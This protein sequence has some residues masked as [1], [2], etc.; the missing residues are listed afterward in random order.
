MEEIDI[1]R[2]TDIVISEIRNTLDED[3]LNPTELKKSSD[4]VISKAP[5]PISEPVI[6][7]LEIYKEYAESNL[8]NIKDSLESYYPDHWDL[9]INYNEIE[10]IVKNCKNKDEI[11]TKVSLYDV[12]YVDVY[13]IIIHFPEIVIKNSRKEEHLIRDLYIK[14]NLNMNFQSTNSGSYF[15]GCRTTITYAEYQSRYSHSHLPRIRLGEGF[16]GFCLGDTTLATLCARLTHSFD[17]ESFDLLLQSLKSYV[18]WESL[19]G[20]PY[21]K[22]SELS[23]N[24]Q[25]PGNLTATKRLQ[26][27][28]K[29]LGQ[30]KDSIPYNT[31][32][33]DFLQIIEISDNKDFEEMITSIVDESD[34]VFYDDVTND[35]FLLSGIT[36]E[37]EITEI[38]KT[39]QHHGFKFKDEDIR[40]KCISENINEKNLKK[41]AN[42]NIT[43]YIANQLQSKINKKLINNILHNDNIHN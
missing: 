37:S 8:N 30:Y 4:K 20:G 28:K 40:Y 29:F 1:E 3:L 38:N 23:G 5:E 24:K 35:R 42:P 14:I 10:E 12:R 9:K 22:I 43:S 41:V 18:S 19:E 33:I 39:Y 11:L 7:P 27:Y 31:K 15:R 32:N 26:Y 2:I 25:P 13:E 6:N 16:K 36:S 21:I 17:E 34:L